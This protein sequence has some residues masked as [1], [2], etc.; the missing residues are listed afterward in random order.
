[1]GGT[2]EIGVEVFASGIAVAIRRDWL[3]V[4]VICCDALV[5]ISRRSSTVS[6]LL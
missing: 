4:Y 3:L 1:M 6:N 5:R 2:D